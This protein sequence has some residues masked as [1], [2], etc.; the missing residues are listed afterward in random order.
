[1]KTLVVGLGNPVLGDG[2]VGWKVATD[3]KRLLPAPP[4]VE[5][6]FLSLG[7]LSLM[8]HLVGYDRAILIDAF[9]LD[10][11]IGSI[12][13]LRLSDMPKY[14]AY[15]TAG[16]NDVSLLNA[17][18]VGRAVGA[19]LPEDIVLVGIATKRIC[20]FSESLSPPIAEVVPQAVQLVLNLLKQP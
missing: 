3:V 7:G 19:K 10:D 18:E 5:V 15:H 6:S 8:Q 1:M 16:R 2:G 9:A 4:N 20:N 12:L 14:S 11:P 13:I 17:I